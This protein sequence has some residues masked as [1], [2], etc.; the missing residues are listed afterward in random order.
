[1]KIVVC[2]KQVVDT[3]ATI[4]L[5]GDSIDWGTSP[6]V[7]NPFDEY[8]VEAALQLKDSL[9]AEVIALTVSADSE[10][11][12]LRRALAM[13]AD[14][15]VQIVH[16]TAAQLDSLSTAKLIAAAIVHIGEVDMVIF[17]R[18]T[19]DM[20]SGVTQAQTARTLRWPMLG[21]I[22]RITVSGNTLNC[23]RILEEEKI[24]VEADLPAVLSIV[25]AI[26]EP[27]YP[28]F[29]GI[30][31]AQKA[32]IQKIPANRLATLKSKI[33][34][35]SYALPAPKTNACQMITGENMQDTAKIVLAKLREAKAL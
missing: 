2:V 35:S 31:R 6:M 30:K 5:N 22:G 25:Q 7:L 3:E 29:I 11:E 28:S 34:H 19:I 4:S 20:G 8:G 1:M 27:R 24:Q 26:G 14:S 12:A 9:S 10:V 23:D 13:G 17:G 16:D 33:D 15:A 32:E 21:Y 18:Q